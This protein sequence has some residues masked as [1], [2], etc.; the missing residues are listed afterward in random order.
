MPVVVEED[1]D[2]NMAVMLRGTG[3]AEVELNRPGSDSKLLDDGD[4]GSYLTT[5][6]PGLRREAL[7]GGPG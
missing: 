2:A 3:A 7:L 5:T 4:E 6:K 1:L